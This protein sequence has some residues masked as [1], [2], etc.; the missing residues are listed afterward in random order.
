MLMGAGVGTVREEPKKVFL[1]GSTTRNSGSPGE[2]IFDAYTGRAN[3]DLL[4]SS[5]LHLKGMLHLQSPPHRAARCRS[6]SSERVWTASPNQARV[7]M[8]IGLHPHRLQPS[9]GP[10]APVST[11]NFQRLLLLC[12]LQNG[13]ETQFLLKY[14]NRIKLQK[15]GTPEDSL[16]YPVFYCKNS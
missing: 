14:S 12:F 10:S 9:S 8:P 5:R 13:N 6:R 11:L 16:F 4:L 15:K 1:S 7:I 2:T 3:I